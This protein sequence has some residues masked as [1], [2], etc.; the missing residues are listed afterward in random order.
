MLGIEKRRDELEGGG[1]SKVRR[2]GICVAEPP[3][4]LLIHGLEDGPVDRRQNSPLHREVRIEVADVAGAFLQETHDVKTSLSNDQSAS[5]I[6]S[7]FLPA[8]V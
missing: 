5:P 3:E 8:W 1:A 4:L 6:G 7:D 2:V